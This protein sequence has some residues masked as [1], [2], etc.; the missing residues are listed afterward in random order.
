MQI[1][2]TTLEAI[3]VINGSSDEANSFETNL[4]SLTFL[5]NIR[6]RGMRE[7]GFRDIDILPQ[8]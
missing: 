4:H 7:K 1:E 6:G 2:N 5:P 3:I 8:N